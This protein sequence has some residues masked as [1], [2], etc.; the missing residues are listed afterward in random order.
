MD[1]LDQLAFLEP[2]E[3]LR[4]F[5]CNKSVMSCM[6]NP[7]KF[8]RQLRDYDLIPEDMYT[9][10]CCMKTKES[11]KAALYDVLDWVERER[12]QSIPLFWRC[13]FKDPILND[14][15]TLRLLRKSLMDGSFK[16]AE[17]DQRKRKEQVRRS[18]CED[19]EEQQP[20]SSSQLPPSQRKKTEKVCFY[21]PLK[22]GQKRD[23][24]TLL[25]NKTQLPV[26]C[27]SKEGMLSRERLAKGEK[28]ILSQ[29][30]WFTPSGFEKFAGKGSCKN[31]KF[32]I[33]FMGSPLARLIKDGH[34]KSATFIR[35][36]ETDSSQAK[37][38][39]FPPYTIFSQLLEHDP[40]KVIDPS[41]GAT[42]VS[43]EEDYDDDVIKIWDEEDDLDNQ[44][45]RVPYSNKENS[46]DVTDEDR[47]TENQMEPEVSKVFKVTCGGEAGTLHQKRFA[48]G[49]RGKCI[50]TERSWL[51]P[52]E[53]LKEASSQRGFWKKMILCEGKPL[54]AL[55]EAKVL[56]IHSLLC[57]C[58]L[59]KPNQTDLP[60]RSSVAHL[61]AH[62]DS[63]SPS[64]M[65]PLDFLKPEELLRFFHCNKTEMSCMENPHTFLRQL[66]DHDLIPEDTYKKVIRLK[67]KESMKAALYDVLDWVERERSQHIHLFWRC[68]FKDT[69][70][71]VYP[72]LR[73]LRNSLM[74]GSFQFGA[75]LPEKEKEETDERKN[76][77]L[78]E[79]EEEEEEQVSSVK[80]KRKLLTRSMCEDDEE[81]QPGPS[82]QLP[83]CRRKKTEKVCFSPPMKKGEKRDIWTW[84]L[85]K[86][87]LPVTCGFQGGML[88]RERLAKGEKC[89]RF[90]KQWFTPSGFEKFAGKGSSKNWM[91]SIKCMDFPLARL[92]KD[93]HLK[94]AN[95]KRRHKTESRRAKRSRCPS[96]GA[97][98]VSEEEEEDDDDD[99]YDDENE[100][101]DLENQEDGVPCSN[102][103]NS[104]DITDEDEATENQTEPEVGK[105]FKVTCGGEAGTLHQK[106]FAS[107]TRGKCIRTE[108]SWLTPIEFLNEASSQQSCWKKDI[109]CEGK[110]LCALIE[111][112]VLKIHSLLCEC[113]L[114]KPN[115]TDLENQKNDDECSVCK[116]GEADLVVCD[117]CPCSF[118]QKCHLPHVDDNLLG[119]DRPWICTFC[120]TTLDW[121]YGDKLKMT[122]ALTHQISE[123]MLECQNLVLRLFSADDQ[124][125]FALDPR[126]YLKSYS[127]YVPTP[128][129]LE[130]VAEKLQGKEYG[131]VGD[132]VSDVKL[133]FTNCA[134]YNRANPELLALGDRLQQ[135]F[136]SEFKVVFNIDEQSAD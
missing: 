62:L 68:V 92:I 88:S 15:P 112:K 25:L 96:D 72:T 104:T 118:H 19:D 131:T 45:D 2:E 17:T 32:S 133:I 63:L 115:Q 36:H 48:S 102:K 1:W 5:C 84:P 98:T 37:R 97:T 33:K 9:K 126:L 35:R 119:D 74:D 135:L 39:L 53:F 12:S 30:Q 107:G 70:L 114:C 82:S 91:F 3:L 22:K 42:T 105:V 122:A 64:V 95:F 87:Q 41:D 60:V 66:R 121:R 128:M 127:K 85:Y 65:D 86:T 125:I 14:Y 79:V 59:C 116:G 73:L 56:K 20:G 16:K 11:M 100:E 130:K 134:S 124:Q 106:R 132:F 90:Q 111:A 50:R 75:Q 76:K 108:W 7:G 18:M 103:E 10:M 58:S 38:S 24:L 43:E 27:G 26:T 110:P 67:K 4:Y 123:H 120:V 28:C 57:E 29:K 77:E 93:G 6:E 51:T 117:S 8:L 99:D 21:S 78:S 136:D 109:V 40:F 31:W 46:T 94:S 80:K 71:N 81:Q 44:E 54:C 61:A 101:D 89:I 113:S 47:A 52:I 23:I 69:I 83:P 13:V 34:L 129:W 49:T 55:I